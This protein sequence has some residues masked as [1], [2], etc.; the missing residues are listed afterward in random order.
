MQFPKRWVPFTILDS[1]QVQVA[2][3]TK[4]NLT[5]LEPI[6]REKYEGLSENEC[7]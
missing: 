1:G 7:T 5:L 2:R 4:C 6:G 3:I